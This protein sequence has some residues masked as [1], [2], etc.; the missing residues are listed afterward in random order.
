MAYLTKE[1]ALQGAIAT[2]ETTMADGRS[3]ELRVPGG[4]GRFD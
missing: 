1:A 2:V 3:I 4:A